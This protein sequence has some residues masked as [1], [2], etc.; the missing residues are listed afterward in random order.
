[1][2]P[3][4]RHDAAVDIAR[5]EA[6]AYALRAEAIAK[7]ARAGA[8]YV[9]RLFAAIGNARRMDAMYRELSAMTDRELRDMGLTRSDIPAVVA[10][11]FT[12]QPAVEL[13]TVAPVEAKPAPA[14]ETIDEDVRIAA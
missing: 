9:A 3:S 4:T 13:K 2:T 5:I 7:A 10:G 14:A 8:R 12:R 1:M 11:T 6:E